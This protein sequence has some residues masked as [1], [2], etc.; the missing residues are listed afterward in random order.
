MRSTHVVRSGHRESDTPIKEI[1]YTSRIVSVHRC[2]QLACLC[3]GAHCKGEGPD[4]SHE[5]VK[6]HSAHRP[7]MSHRRRALLR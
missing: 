2:E 1:L 3:A 7:D 4:C 5:Q 6:G